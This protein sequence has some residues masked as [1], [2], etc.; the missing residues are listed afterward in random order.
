MMVQ[1]FGSF[2]LTSLGGSSF[3][4]APATAPKL[5]L[6]PLAS[7]VM[8]LFA[9]RH[10]AAGTDH[11]WAAAVISI[12]RAAAP[13]LRRYSCDRRMVRLP[14]DP[15]SPHTRPRRTCSFTGAYSTL[16]LLQS[17]P[18]SSATSCAADVMLPWPISER[19]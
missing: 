4:A 3:A 19:A 7:W 12:S 6:R 18:S 1:L 5:S 9:A 10:S 15:M 2:S 8:T 16:T 17:Q 11:C 14:T 13:P